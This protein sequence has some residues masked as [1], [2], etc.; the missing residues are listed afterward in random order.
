MSI[1]AVL[2]RETETT[3]KGSRGG[4]TRRSLLAQLARVSRETRTA[5]RLS[6]SSTLVLWLMAVASARLFLALSH[7]TFLGIDGGAYLLGMFQF[8]G[9]G[10]EQAGFDRP[11]LAP[12]YLLVPFI[13]LFGVTPL[14]YNLYAALGSMVLWPSFWLL[15]RRIL[16]VWWA[17]LATVLVSLDWEQWIMFV[18]GVVPITGFSGLC[19]ALWAMLSLAEE[20]QRRGPIIALFMTI[21][22]IAL[23]NQTS[24]GLGLLSLSAA[25]VALPNK[26]T[27][28]TWLGLSGV[29]AL[30]V[31]FP[32]YQGVLPGAERV[33]V[34][35]PLFFLAPFTEY[36]WQQA[37]L[38]ILA[39]L[40]IETLWRRAVD[41]PLGIK[42]LSFVVAVHVS[43]LL[44]WSSDEALQNILFRG[45]IWL[46]VPFWVLAAWAASQLLP[47][48]K[49]WFS[50]AV[51]AAVLF[52][53]AAGAVWLYQRQ[54][55]YSTHFSRDVL[56]AV[57]TL[58]MDTVTRIGTNG[59]SR[60]YWLSAVSGKPVAWLQQ[61]R[62]QPSY[63]EQERQARCEIGWLPECANGYV[64]HWIVDRTE[65][66]QVSAPIFVAP[67]PE[68]P[69]S[70][71]GVDAPWL[72][73]VWRQGQVE[74]WGR[75]AHLDLNS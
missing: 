65:R 12:G 33:A 40:G 66:Q 75:L 36:Q 5:A 69:W 16:P 10:P 3:G 53:G 21:P 18:T 51:V 54:E 39:L 68:E 44:I 14:G 19:I 59:E 30:V 74:V 6:P 31:A 43:V 57:Q 56:D 34:P 48:F 70:Q 4:N 35:G 25:W 1:E 42:M 8:W 28:A 45:G 62:P 55:L 32:W 52:V 7:D 13:W 41:P 64:S 63:M 23:S 50:V 20:P 26:R 73:L 22:L 29:L 49:T 61:A 71:I 72:E 37:A 58:D 2:P 24:A 11:P 47:G 60:A 46:M 38:V 17:V 9:N 15:A 27:V 67:K